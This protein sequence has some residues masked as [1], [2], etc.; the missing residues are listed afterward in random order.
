MTVVVA[1]TTIIGANGMT[2]N[3]STVSDNSANDGAGMYNNDA[4]RLCVTLNDST[5]DGN[6]ASRNGGGI[7]NAG[8]GDVIVNDSI[9]SDNTATDTGVAFTMALK[10]R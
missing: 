9:V 7:L 3:E 4:N 2:L 6:T 10:A 1:S 8:T 5:I